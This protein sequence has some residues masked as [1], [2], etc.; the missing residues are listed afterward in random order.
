MSNLDE[1][2]LPTH[3]STDPTSTGAEGASA[4][5]GTAAA[6]QSASATNNGDVE[7]DDDDAELEA[8]KARVAEMEAEAAKLREMQEQ[9][10]REMGGLGASS[11][12]PGP[13]EEEKEEVDARSI[14]VGNVSGPR[15]VKL[16][17]RTATP[18]C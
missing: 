17:T 13:S 4:T 7:L 8:M 15:S 10:D 12:Q 14:Y 1:I 6:E 5:D 3:S 11:R 9:A 16:P 18:P 2:D